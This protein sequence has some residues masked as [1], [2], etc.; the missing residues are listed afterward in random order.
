MQTMT[1][2]AWIGVVATVVA[3][4]AGLVDVGPRAVRR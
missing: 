4:A 2:E 1:G 3:T